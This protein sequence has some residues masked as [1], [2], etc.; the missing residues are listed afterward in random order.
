MVQGAIMEA[1]KLHQS[2][3]LNYE[4]TRK[5][6][7]FGRVNCFE[8]IRLPRSSPP[9]PLIIA[10]GWIKY[11]LRSRV[12]ISAV[13]LRATDGKPDEDEGHKRSGNIS[14]NITPLNVTLKERSDERWRRID[15]PNSTFR[16]LSFVLITDA[17]QFTIRRSNLVVGGKFRLAETSCPTRGMPVNRKYFRWKLGRVADLVKLFYWRE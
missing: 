15:Q 2:I 16:F 4:E 3:S 14:K 17:R 13:V 9:G 10:K 6:E 7:N 5:R 1:R 8:S 11:W 12:K